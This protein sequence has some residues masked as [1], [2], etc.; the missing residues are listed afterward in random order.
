MLFDKITKN[1]ITLALVDADDTEYIPMIQSLK[2]N[3][4]AHRGGGIRPFLSHN[5]I[6]KYLPSNAPIIIYIINIICPNMLK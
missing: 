1:E 5:D 6:F 4:N 2:P 3:C